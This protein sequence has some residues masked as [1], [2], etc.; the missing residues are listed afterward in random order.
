MRG[1]LSRA[2]CIAAVLLAERSG[3]SPLKPPQTLQETGLYVD[4][5]TLHVDPD[6]L[7]FAPQ[8]P[9]W[10][11][12][13]AK[14]RWISLPPGT[15][16]DASDPD[17]WVFPGRHPA[18]EGILL[19][20]R[21]RRDAL[22]RAENRR[23]VALRRLCVEP[24]WPGRDARART[25]QAQCLR[26]RRRTRAHDPRRQRLQGV[27]SGRPQR[28]AGFQR[29]AA[30]ARARSECAARGETVRHRSARPDRARPAG[31]ASGV[32][33]A[34]SN[35]SRVRHRACR[36]RL[37]AWQLRALPQRTRP[38]EQCRPFPAPAARMLPARPS[39]P[40]RHTR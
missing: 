37:S 26:A 22:P 10:T 16:I 31:R 13:A 2:G 9:L 8:Y 34:A 28:G 6:H 27:P 17:A 12:G 14:R 32:P 39:R 36:T 15:A 29:A 3:S 33:R 40:P 19:R 21:A 20:G 1:V 23:A 24:G 35:H 4:F 18:V 7:A 5:A 38:A 11:D 30:L 25:R